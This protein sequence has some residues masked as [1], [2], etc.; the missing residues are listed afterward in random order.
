M[1]LCKDQDS[2]FAPLV[3][4]LAG[5][6]V[7]LTPR[8]EIVFANSAMR[9]FLGYDESTPLPRSRH[10]AWSRV[11]PADRRSLF[12][13]IAGQL[14]VGAHI[15]HSCQLR[16]QDGSYGWFKIHGGKA[17]LSPPLIV[18]QVLDE[19]PLR[20][21]ADRCS[22]NEQRARIICDQVQDIVIDWDLTRD[23][24]RHA[25]S[26]EPK[27]GYRLPQDISVNELLNSD[28][29][30]C[31][32]KAIV[33]QAFQRIQAGTPNIETEHRLKLADGSYI[34]FRNRMV[35]IF[36]QNGKPVQ[37]VG[38]L[39]DIDAFRRELAVLQ[40]KIRLDPLTGLLNRSTLEEQMRVYLEQQEPHQLHA[41]F[42][43]DVDK[44]EWI[45]STLG[46]NTGDSVLKEAAVCLAEQFRDNDLVA[47]IGGDRFCALMKDLPTRD[48]IRKKAEQLNLGFHRLFRFGEKVCSFSVS[49]GVAISAD[50]D[51]GYAD[52][53]Q[54]ADE[55][56][57]CSKA[58][59]GD[60][61]TIHNEDLQG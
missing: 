4:A 30:H 45:N 35:A 26:F 32:D 29:V 27:F 61:F 56:I 31:D 13:A 41:F 49:V 53:W 10:F 38:L 11:H 54:R 17:E 21:L 2:H 52:F 43:I 33:L 23:A 37:A 6:V 48:V 25:D 19:T 22:R 7:G 18:L 55:A 51:L 44:F 42:L 14:R 47:R 1:Q 46:Q 57:A 40:E 34:W 39:A 12:R 3:D 50:G 60:C 5:G 28:L 24:I 58:R 20:Q 15:D 9:E 36:D 8:G 59:G 16:R